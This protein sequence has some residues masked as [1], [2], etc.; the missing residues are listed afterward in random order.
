MFRVLRNNGSITIQMG[1]GKSQGLKDVSVDYYDNFFEAYST[2]G[3][4]DVMIE[5]Y[6]DV[7]NDLLEI[8]FDNF[9]YYISKVGPGDKHQHWIFF[10]AQKV[11]NETQ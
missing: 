5:N 6:I 1:Y 4:M 8:G 11:M 7:K 9:N 3:G 2:N 10:S